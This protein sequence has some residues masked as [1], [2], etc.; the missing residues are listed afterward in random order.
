[1]LQLPFYIVMNILSS[2]QA[3][4]QEVKLVVHVHVHVVCTHFNVI[5]HIHLYYYTVQY[6][7]IRIGVT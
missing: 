5:V 1:M 7:Y 6:G 4:T 3:H 2:E